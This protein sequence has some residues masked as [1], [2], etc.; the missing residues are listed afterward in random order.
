MGA[1]PPLVRLAVNLPVDAPR[2]SA[3]LHRLARY[4][5][6]IE[7]TTYQVDKYVDFHRRRGLKARHAFDGLL[8][9]LTG[10]G[11]LGLALAD[12]YTGTLSRAS[13]VRQK[14]MLTLAILESS[15]PSFATLDAPDAGGKLV[16]LR[17]AQR[18]ASAAIL[19]ALSVALLA[20]LH[21]TY[22]LLG[23]T[24]RG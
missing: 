20:P 4:V 11:W 18:V 16:F 1:A 19:L 9:K 7:P 3:E 10:A 2:L 22:A 14:L 8:F 17:M 23:R 6:G 5:A 15:A 21:A 24:R 12:A 13:L